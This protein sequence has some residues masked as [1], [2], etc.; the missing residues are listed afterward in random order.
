MQHH[1]LSIQ[2]KYRFKLKRSV[3]YC[4]Q[5][6][7][8]CT[9]R[10]WHQQLFDDS[11]FQGCTVYN[12]DYSQLANISWGERPSITTTET[13]PCLYGIHYSFEGQNVAKKFD[14]GC[15]DGKL[16]PSTWQSLS[17]IGRVV[18]YLVMGTLSDW[19]G[20]KT[21][22]FISCICLPITAI[23]IVVSNSY[24]LFIISNLINS[25]FNGG[26]AVLFIL[27]MEISGNIH[28]SGFLAVGCC[29]FALGIG[30]TPMIN[31]IIKSYDITVLIINLF[32]LIILLFYRI[33]PES[34]AWLF[35]THKINDIQDILE[36]AAKINKS[37]LNP[38]LKLIYADNNDRNNQLPKKRIFIWDIV[39][40]PELSYEI[41]GITYLTA[42]YGL[43]FGSS[44][45][46]I[47]EALS[48]SYL[49]NSFIALAILI[50]MLCG[51][52]CLFLMGHKKILQIS[53]YLVFLSSVLLGIDLHEMEPL[54]TGPTITLLLAN[55]SLVSLSYGVLLNYNV[56]TIPTLLR[57]T[58]SGIWRAVWAIFVWLGNHNHI[59]FPTPTIPLILTCLVAGLFCLNFKDVHGR[60]LPDTILDAVN[61]KV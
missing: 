7:G 59:K 2:V 24:I 50:G 14:I 16:F 39:F 22:L 58:F 33:L 17:I 45:Y 40:K 10:K 18:G 55:I 29:C 23:L 15:T 30:L 48:K 43:I 11:Y 9:H 27:I 20:R 47:L 12:I 51:Q 54:N 3:L 13:A 34:P 36:K 28:R 4:D 19:I 37:Y 25:F 35:V 46:S 32:F 21:I 5:C 49:A 41:I 44:Y 26:L 31:H 61:F 56:R 52:I 60:E 1:Y 8:I 53:I 38:Y 6:T 42:L 57:G